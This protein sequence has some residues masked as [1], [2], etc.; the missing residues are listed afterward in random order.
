MRDHI[1][2]LDQLPSGTKVRVGNKRGTVVSSV[3][4]PAVPAGMIYVHTVKLIEKYVGN[5]LRPNRWETI[6]PQTLT[7]GYCSIFVDERKD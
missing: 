2:P 6:K 4:V 7:V 3:Y 1:G 5:N